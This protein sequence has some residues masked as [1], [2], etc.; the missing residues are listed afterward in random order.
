MSSSF[1]WGTPE[2]WHNLWV[3]FSG[4]ICFCRGESSHLLL[5][6]AGEFLEVGVFEVGLAVSVFGM[7]WCALISLV[8]VQLTHTSFPSLHLLSMAAVWFLVKSA[9]QC[10]CHDNCINSIHCGAN[11][12]CSCSW[13]ASS[14]LLCFISA[15][16]V[17]HNSSVWPVSYCPIVIFQNVQTPHLLCFVFRTS[18]D[19]LWG[20]VPFVALLY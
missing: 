11:V 9:S 5:F 2:L 10:S 16:P 4:I 13:L 19:Y 3:S 1:F 7:R 14:H 15:S 17:F 12:L 6:L 20:W 8:W 18:L